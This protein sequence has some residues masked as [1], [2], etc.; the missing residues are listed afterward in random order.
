MLRGCFVAIYYV[1]IIK[2]GGGA[3]LLM[4]VSEYEFLR[5]KF[6]KFGAEV[7]SYF[8]SQTIADLPLHILYLGMAAI[9]SFLL[10]RL[11]ITLPFSVI[12]KKTG[13]EADKRKQ[14]ILS[15]IVGVLLFI[16]LAV[17]LYYIVIVMQISDSKC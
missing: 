16:I 1:I 5:E 8:A 12:E 7:Y 9:A 6:V 15:W 13:L 2:N 10:C 17:L 4:T 11:F 14:K 3:M